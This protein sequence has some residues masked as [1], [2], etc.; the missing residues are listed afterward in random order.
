MKSSPWTLVGRRSYNRSMAFK[1]ENLHI[2]QKASD[3]TD[4]I[5][6]LTKSFPKDELYILAS[7]V[8]RVAGPVVLNLAEGCTGQ[9]NAG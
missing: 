9:S 1:L 6:N 4:K 8:K 3:S 5:N 2:R 7:Q